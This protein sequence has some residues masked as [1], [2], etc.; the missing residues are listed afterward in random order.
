MKELFKANPQSE[1]LKKGLAISNSKLGAIHQAMGHIEHALKFFKKFNILSLELY[2]A[3]PGNI[4]LLEGLGISY[5]NLAQYYKTVGNNVKGK[6]HFGEWKRITSFL[7]KNVLQVPKYQE[8]NEIEYDYQANTSETNY[9]AIYN[10]NSEMDNAS[11]YPCDEQQCIFDL[12]QS[13]E[14]E[15]AMQLLSTE[16]AALRNDKSKA[17]EYQA[18]IGEQAYV[19][20]R[21]DRF[22]E[23]LQKYEQQAE[24]CLKNRL[25]EA[26][27]DCLLSQAELL[28]EEMDMRKRAKVILQKVI[29]EAQKNNFI[30]LVVEAKEMLKGLG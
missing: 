4:D 15:I 7:A 2:E 21:M 19:L 20:T 27:C 6:E 1:F 29:V 10:A 23:A 5:Q 3:N 25:E 30:H 9:D 26:Y 12:I 28:I 11:K 24:I 16:Q 13:G 18:N 14:Y 17:F 22:G 8:W